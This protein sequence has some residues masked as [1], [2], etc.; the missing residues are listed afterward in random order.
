MQHQLRIL[1]LIALVFT[2]AGCG[3]HKTPAERA[4]WFFEKGESYI[5]DSL[6]DHGATKQQLEKVEST[7]NQH[8]IRVTNSLEQALVSQ[9]EVMKGIMSGK[10]D[11]E[12]L[13]LENKFHGA[14]Q[15]AL[16][17]IG[18]MHKELENVVGNKIWSAAA[19]ERENRFSRHSR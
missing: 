3:M 11:A 8:K 4:E 13:E 12:L 7:M 2:I 15:N 10:N 6:D 5:A 1:T 19:T 18:T 9:R 16:R 14:N 17:S